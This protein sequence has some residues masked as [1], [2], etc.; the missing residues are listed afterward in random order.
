MLPILVLYFYPL[1]IIIKKQL[2][3]QESL[4][5]SSSAGIEV[6]KLKLARKTRVDHVWLNSFQFS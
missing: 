5:V 4:L 3:I 1:R 2:A 6:V